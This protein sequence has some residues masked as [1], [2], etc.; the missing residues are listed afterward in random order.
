M[1]HRAQ[2]RLPLGRE[3]KKDLH[4]GNGAAGSKG[5]LC[6][7]QARL[8]GDAETAPINPTGELGG[9]DMGYGIWDTGLGGTVARL[10]STC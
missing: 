10:L 1:T 7:G 9:M 4:A 6:R 5:V 8:Q 2:G 3:T